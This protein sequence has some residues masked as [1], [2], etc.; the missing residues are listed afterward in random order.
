MKRLS[1]KLVL[2]AS[3]VALA[4]FAVGPMARAADGKS[5]SGG[6]SER[7]KH[8]DETLRRYDRNANGKLDPDEEAARKAD[9]ERAKNDG[10]K[11]KG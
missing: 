9:E 11:K 1:P 10:K 3:A 6:G 7:K 8:D 2:C 4:F 5:K